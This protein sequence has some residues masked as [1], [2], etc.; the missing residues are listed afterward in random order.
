MSDA[1]KRPA[2]TVAERARASRARR[3]EAGEPP[4]ATFDRA[5]REA[6]FAAYGAGALSI[7]VP[8][9]VG[10]VT[11]SLLKNSEHKERGVAS[12]VRALAAK[13]EVA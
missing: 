9:L 10:S 7:D 6:V 8:D 13:A 5:L 1:E 12:L 3:K 11:A 2:L 4:L